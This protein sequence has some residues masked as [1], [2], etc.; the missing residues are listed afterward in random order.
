MFVPTVLPTGIEPSADPILLA[1][2]APYAI[3]LGR[4]LGG[5]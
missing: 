4:R 5:Q 2:A 1:R 3:S